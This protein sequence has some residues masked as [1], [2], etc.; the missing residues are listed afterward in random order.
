MNKILVFSKESR[1]GVGTFL[2]S[3]Q[4]LNMKKT[5]VLIYLYKKEELTNLKEYQLVNHYYPQGFDFSL[6]KLFL[7]LIN[8]KKT[9][10]IILKEKPTLILTADQ[11]SAFLLLF[12]K[13]VFYQSARVI[14]IINNN[15]IQNINERSSRLYRSLLKI[16]YKVLLPLSCKIIFVS[17][18]LAKMMISS[19]NLTEEQCKVIYC[20]VH[21]DKRMKNFLH[22]KSSDKRK[23][24]IFITVG[25][26]DKQKDFETILYAFSKIKNLSINIELHLVGEGELRPWLENLAETLSIKSNTFFLGWR[27]NIKYFL[28]KADI[29][30][31]SSFYEGMPLSVLEAM[32][33]GLPIIATDTPYGIKEVLGKNK[34]G[35]L[36]KMHNEIQMARAM[37]NLVKNIKVR[38]LYARL[39]SRRIEDFTEVKMLQSY[40]QLFTDLTYS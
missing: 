3:I 20:G 6:E 36:I 13:L 38:K 23:K 5:S 33:C 29:F 35:I 25:R 37:T 32:S 22:K 8:L 24:V 1:G 27:K 2:R 17:D 28:R 10:N 31:F 21:V 30:I 7:F 11:Y 40:L 14:V 34:F 16:T 12:L 19:F 15:I 9:Y 18:E 26:F 4:R 39:S